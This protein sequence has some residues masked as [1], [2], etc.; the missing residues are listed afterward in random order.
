MHSRKVHKFSFIRFELI[1]FILFLA[2]LKTSKKNFL[3]LLQFHETFVYLRVP[4][5]F[6]PVNAFKQ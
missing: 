2:Y 1:Y 3:L 6:V 4:I 5:V